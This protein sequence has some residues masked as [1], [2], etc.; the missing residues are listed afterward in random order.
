VLL[1]DLAIAVLAA[2]VVLAVSSG[3]AVAAMIA[4]VVLIGCAVS[5]R[6]EARRRHAA[7]TVRGRRTSVAPAGARSEPR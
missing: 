2:I 6:L 7:R 5:G 3:L 1:V 4:I